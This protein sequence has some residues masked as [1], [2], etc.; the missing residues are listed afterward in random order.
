MQG[1]GRP[2]GVLFPRQRRRFRLV[3]EQEVQ[4]AQG[5]LHGF[6]GLPVFRPGHIRADRH[7]PAFARP[8]HLLHLPRSQK[9]RDEHA[10]QTEHIRVPRQ[11][12]QDVFPAQ[13]AQAPLRIGQKTPFPVPLHENQIDPR[14][15]PLSG[16]PFFHQDPAL[17]AVL[18]DQFSGHILPQHGQKGHRQRAVFPLPFRFF[19]CRQARQHRGFVKRVP[20][21]GKADPIRRA[22]SGRENLRP[23]IH[24]HR[25][26]NGRSRHDDFLFP[27]QSL[28]LSFLLFRSLTVHSYPRF[29]PNRILHNHPFIQRRIAHIWLQVLS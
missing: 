19:R 11:P 16:R 13:P 23:H 10:G 18:Q 21:C 9:R 28:H 5:F 15:Q 7:S 3:G 26:Q 27:A 2:H 14:I 6:H 1:P 24:R 4:L 17:R 12:S 8:K 22:G 25:I 29:L 20:T